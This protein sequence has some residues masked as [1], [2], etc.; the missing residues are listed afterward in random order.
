MQLIRTL[1]GL[2]AGASLALAG[3]GSARAQ[4]ETPLAMKVYN[5][6]GKSF[7]VNSVLLT[8]AR[9]AILV[10]AQFTR[11]DAHRV[12]ADILASGKTLKA[13]YVSHGDPDFYFGLEVIRAEFPDVRVFAS[14]PTVEWIRNTVHKKQAFWGPKM[15]ANA[16]R[17]PVIPELLPSAGLE[18]EGRK[19]EVLGLDGEQPGRS[20]VWI[21]SIRA[22]IGG[23][24][25]F[26]G[27]HLWTADTQTK[28][29]R[30]A[31]LG[32]LERIA[33]LDPVTVVPGHAAS[34]PVD[35]R[36]ALAYSRDYLVRFEQ[37]LERSA[38][39]AALIEAM[40]QHYPEAG[41]PIALDI[42]ARVNKG[43]MKW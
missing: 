14:A 31:W 32:T 39:A 17:V 34:V 43:E 21:P 27:L 22:V 15:G 12:V 29:S 35:A 1:A 23:V 11:A 30:A 36:A 8:G 37:E 28:A 40:K 20:F 2:A 3:T 26:T 33:A 19:L 4:T 25:V 41:L 5:A 38:N 10:D 6:D 24:N 18:L 13:V 9:D 42:G 16:P 7:H